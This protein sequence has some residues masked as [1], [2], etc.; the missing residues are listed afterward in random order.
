MKPDTRGQKLLEII[1]HGLDSEKKKKKCYS[2]FSS[3]NE[4]FFEK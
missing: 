2:L 4:I 1:P 3:H